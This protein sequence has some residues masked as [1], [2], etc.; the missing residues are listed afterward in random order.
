MTL[1][2]SITTARATARTRNGLRFWAGAGLLAGA[3]MWGTAAQAANVYW[4]IGVQAPGALIEVANAPR[5]VYG[6]APV[7]VVPTP[8]YGA[9][10][11]PAYPKRH[12][13]GHHRRHHD[14]DRYERY[15]DGRRW[16]GD[17]G[18]RWERHDDRGH[19]RR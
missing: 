15:D 10:W 11:G 8:V 6:P 19:H 14:H 12:W 9:A 16:D 7:V 18:E 3:A 4:N 2:S 5:V 1:F 17:R 13:H